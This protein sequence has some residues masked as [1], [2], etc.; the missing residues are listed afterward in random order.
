[1]PSRFRPGLRSAFVALALTGVVGLTGLVFRSHVRS[2]LTLADLQ[3]DELDASGPCSAGR[4][5]VKVL[6]DAGVNA[7]R[8]QAIPSSVS[9]LGALPRPAGIDDST[10]RLPA[11]TATYTVRATIYAD[12]LESDRDIHLVLKDPSNEAQMIAELPDPSCTSAADPALQALMTASRSAYVAACG[13]ASADSG[14]YHVQA[15]AQVT[16]IRLFDTLVGQF[17]R[18]PN[19]VELHPVLGIKILSACRKLGSPTSFGITS[20]LTEGAIA[21]GT[22]Q[23]TATADSSSVSSVEFSVDGHTVGHF[24]AGS[25]E[26]ISVDTRK[27]TDGV[28]SFGIT[29]VLSNGSTS[30]LVNHLGTANGIPS[31]A[32]GTLRLTRGRVRRGTSTIAL[33]ARFASHTPVRLTLSHSRIRIATS[34]TTSRSDGSARVLVKIPATAPTGRYIVY[35]CSPGCAQIASRPAVVTP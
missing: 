2:N 26:T 23:W 20:S 7:I 30:I 15:T 31:P 16:G 12:H 21:R 14:N 8:L 4:W 34:R 32:P 18:A 5:P 22:L 25:T 3:L 29:A 35:A 1:M 28:H 17:G 24:G 10:P 19:A 13:P 9:A 11:E 6:S 27:L 33:V